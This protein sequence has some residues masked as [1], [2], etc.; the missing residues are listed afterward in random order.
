MERLKINGGAISSHIV[1]K[2]VVIDED[3]PMSHLRVRSKRATVSDCISFLRQGV[4]VCVF[5]TF[6]NPED[7]DDEKS[8]EPVSFTILFTFCIIGS[9]Q[10]F[11]AILFHTT[12]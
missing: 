3:L 11:L 5:S 4:D 12:Y 10:S 8:D 9:V 6:H 7:S 2:G 1:E